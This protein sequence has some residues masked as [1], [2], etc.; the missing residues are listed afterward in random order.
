MSNV[1]SVS[2]WKDKKVLITGGT[3]FVGTHLHK[4]LIK[5]GALVWAS[6]SLDANLVENPRRFPFLASD[7][8]V[9]F[10]LAANVGGMLYNMRNPTQILYDNAMMGLNLLHMC[11]Q[12]SIPHIQFVSTA[13]VYSNKCSVPTPENQGFI[14]DPEDTNFAYGWSKRFIEKAVEVYAK[15]SDTKFSIVR[16][17]NTY[18]PGDNFDPN[19]SHVIPALIRK[20][21]RADEDPIVIKGTGTS[22]R[23]FLYV[24]DFARGLMLTVEKA[25]GLT[26]FNIGS[27]EEISIHNLVKLIASLTGYKGE[28]KYDSHYPDGQPRRQPDLF[29]AK[30][31]LGFETTVP[32]EEGLK[33]TIK[34]FKEN[35]A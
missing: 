19:D 20:F 29:R 23:S 11:S 6:G 3:G 28:I 27:D 35:Y 17:Y 13:C 34:Y 18:G 12:L 16:P 33:K 2:F 4:L 30:E 31:I 14:G 9:I 10:H 5:E 26:P 25:K 7:K 15:D 24:E 32:L 1:Q 22:T 8:D 21:V